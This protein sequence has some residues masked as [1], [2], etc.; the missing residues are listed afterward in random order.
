M[1]EVEKALGLTYK[2]SKS[3]IPFFFGPKLGHTF[4]VCAF[5]FDFTPANEVTTN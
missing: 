1:A 5:L 4:H 2:L 3:F